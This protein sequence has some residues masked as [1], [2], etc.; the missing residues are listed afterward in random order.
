MRPPGIAAI[1]VLGVVH[2]AHHDAAWLLVEDDAP[3]ADSETQAPCSLQVPHIAVTREGEA[4][5]A[6]IM[7]SARRWLRDAIRASAASAGG[8]Q[9]TTQGVQGTVNAQHAGPGVR[10]AR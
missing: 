2:G 1:G 9:T 10:V 3:I 6:A 5:A 4:S 7:H 8:G